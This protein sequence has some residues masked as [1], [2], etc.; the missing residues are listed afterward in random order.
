[1]TDPSVGGSLYVNVLNISAM[2]YHPSI[3]PSGK[4]RSRSNEQK[5]RNA[6]DTLWWSSLKATIPVAGRS[7]NNLQTQRLV[8]VKH[9]CLC[10]VCRHTV[11]GK[12]RKKNVC[13]SG[14]VW[15]KHMVKYCLK[16]TLL[17]AEKEY[18]HDFSVSGQVVFLQLGSVLLHPSRYDVSFRKTWT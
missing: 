15:M 12:R 6:L 9:G 18:C 1:M 13:L 14:A 5:H 16:T 10:H 2:L 7:Q 17:S 11:L 3:L 4:L 8:G